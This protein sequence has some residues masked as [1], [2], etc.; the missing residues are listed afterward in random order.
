MTDRYARLEPGLVSFVD[1][2][3]AITVNV[4]SIRNSLYEVVV[5]RIIQKL[6]VNQLFASTAVG[7]NTSGIV[8]SLPLHAAVPGTLFWTEKA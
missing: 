3:T 8:T 7:L 4:R 6:K 5:I 1:R 2:Y